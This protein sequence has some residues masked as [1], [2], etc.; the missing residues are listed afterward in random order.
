MRL[1][2]DSCPKPPENKPT[3]WFQSKDPEHRELNHIMSELLTYRTVSL[4]MGI[5][6]SHEVYSNLS[7]GNKKQKQEAK[8]FYKTKMLTWD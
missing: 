2:A 3:P 4:Q 5:V 8:H 6:L 1:G 7:H